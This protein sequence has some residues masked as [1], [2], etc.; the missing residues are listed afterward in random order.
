[1]DRKVAKLKKTSPSSQTEEATPDG[2]QETAA[3]V[4][5]AENKAQ[6]CLLQVTIKLYKLTKYIF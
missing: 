1:M 2:K 6:K 5:P 3:A 4:P